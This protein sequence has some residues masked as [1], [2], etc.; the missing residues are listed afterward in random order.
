M[1]RVKRGAA[2]LP[3][4][5]GKDRPDGGADA[6]VGVTG[7]QHDPGGI[8]RGGD[9]EPPLAQGPQDKDVQKS[10]VSASPRAMFRDLPTPFGRHAGGHHQRPAD[11]PPAHSHVQV[12]GV[13]EDVGEPG[14][15]Q[16][17]G[18]ELVHALVDARRGSLRPWSG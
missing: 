4:G 2:A 8:L 11:H 6:G 14:A 16:A 13:H 7:D 10:V 3:G 9:L 15:V 1:L 17:A 18:Q 5:S 12:R